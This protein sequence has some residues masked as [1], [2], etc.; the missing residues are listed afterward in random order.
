M[1]HAMAEQQDAPQVDEPLV[2]AALQLFAQRPGARWT[3]ESLARALGTSRPVLNRR[4]KQA[5]GEPPLSA[6]R[7]FR[8]EKAAALLLETDDCLAA[9]ADA[10]GYDSEFAL[11]RAFYR[12]HQVRPGAWRQLGGPRRS[13]VA[14]CAA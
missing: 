5:L 6:L 4:F 9:I 8:M 1:L 12:H 10:V 14:R 11:S 2:A 13:P 3:V 7:K